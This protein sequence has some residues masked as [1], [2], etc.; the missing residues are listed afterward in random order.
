MD[1]KKKRI[2]EVCASVLL[3]AYGSYGVVADNF[4][5]PAKGGGTVTLYGY[6]AWTMYAALLCLVANLLIDAFGIH[7]SA[8]RE[9]LYRKARTSLAIAGCALFILALILGAVK[10]SRDTVCENMELSRIGI[11]QTTYSVVVFNRT[12]SWPKETVKDNNPNILIAVVNENEKIPS[13][14]HFS[15]TIWMNKAALKK[16]MWLDEKLFVVYQ[17]DKHLKVGEKT[18]NVRNAFPLPVMLVDLDD[19]ARKGML[20]MPRAAAVRAN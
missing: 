15:S 6:P 3:I 7:I 16:I 11:P 5:I 4:V 19:P 20:Y 18:P 13:D 14:I 2:F 8:G 17:D 12:C 10:H 1:I 9:V